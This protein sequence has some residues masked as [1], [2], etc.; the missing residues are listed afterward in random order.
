MTS[1]FPKQIE[2]RNFLSPVGFLFSLAKYPK[3]SFFSNAARIPEI[4]YPSLEQPSYLKSISVPATVLKYGSLNLKFL[5]DEDLTNYTIIHNWLTGLGFPKSTEQFAR[6][7]NNGPY[8]SGLEG[9]VD[10]KKHFSDGSLTILNSNYNPSVVVKFTDLHPT[11]L[12]SLEFDSTASDIKYFTAEVTFDYTLYEL[13]DK[14][15]NLL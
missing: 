15:G 10:T 13:T 3:V 7:S 2:N 4:S 8:D 12:S 5:V 11:S 1:S 9:T 14:N 6:F